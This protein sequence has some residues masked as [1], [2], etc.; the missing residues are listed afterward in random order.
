MSAGDGRIEVV[1]EE[2]IRNRVP[3]VES[4]AIRNTGTKRPGEDKVLLKKLRRGDAEAVETLFD[5]YHGKVYNLAMSIL[6]NESDA[7]EATQDVFLTVVRKAYMFKGNSALYSWIYRICVNACLMRLRGKRRSET[8]SIE[9]F[10]PLFTE[11]GMHA[12]PVNDW[13]KEVERKALDKELGQVIRKFTDNL[14]ERY[15]MVFIL[16]DVEGLSNE[17]TAQILGLTVPAVKSRLHRA[18]LYLRE[19]LSGYLREGSL[20]LNGQGPIIQRPAA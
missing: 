10:L 4:K 6:K 19:R 18:R 17:E 13:S 2:H 8:V 14:S 15:R 7:E 5:R 16:S 9:E 3:A 12:N 11:D 20:S 1:V